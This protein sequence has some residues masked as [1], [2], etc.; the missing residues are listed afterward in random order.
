MVDALTDL[1]WS[2]HST[3]NSTAVA[4]VPKVELKLPLVQV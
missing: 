4:S 3:R 1:Q 2:H